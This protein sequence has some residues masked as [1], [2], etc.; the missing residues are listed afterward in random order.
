MSKVITLGDG[1][2]VTVDAERHAA[3]DTHRASFSQILGANPVGDSQE[4]LAFM[5]G[6]LTYTEGQVFER[7]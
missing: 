2:T 1:R 6:Q 7:Q 3:F 5:I 4:A